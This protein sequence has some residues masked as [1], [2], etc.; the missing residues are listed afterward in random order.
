MCDDCTTLYRTRAPFLVTSDS[1]GSD[2]E[3]EVDGEENGDVRSAEDVM[4]GYLS[5]LPRHA[6]L[7]GMGAMSEWNDAVM[8][9]LQALGEQVDEHGEAVLITGEMVQAVAR[10]AKEEVEATRRRRRDA[11]DDLEGADGDGA[12]S[13]KRGRFEE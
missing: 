5:S 13:T 11:V 10:E 4:D 3:E 1:D 2:E 12:N 7:E 9:R 6:L 8:R